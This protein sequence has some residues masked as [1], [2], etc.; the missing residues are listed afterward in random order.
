MTLSKLTPSEIT[1]FFVAGVPIPQPRQRHRVM[2]VNGKYVA[3]SYVSKSHPVQE[4]KG[5][6]RI[7]ARNPYETP[8]TR[9]VE[10]ALEFTLPRPSSRTRK[11]I[12]N[13]PYWSTARPDI[14][15]LVKAV[16]D[17][18]TDIAW[19]DDTQVARLMASKLVA[20]DDDEVGVMISIKVMDDH[21]RE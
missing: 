18:L 10:I 3:T 15:N 5:R 11:T 20:G 13:A 21:A 2:Q 4:W 16:L 6:I 12:E 7:I 8:I 1:S 19:D 17:A 9:P 14:D